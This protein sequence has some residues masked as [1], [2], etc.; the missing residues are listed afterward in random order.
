EACTRLFQS[1][2]Q[3]DSSA[4]R[5]F[6]GTGLGLA[7]S[8]QLVEL[9]GGEIG[10]E[11]QV[12]RGST[13]WFN[14]TFDRSNACSAHTAP[15]LLA[16]EGKRVL[17]VD[18]ND[19]NRRLLTRLL[20]RWQLVPVEAKNGHEAL[21]LLRAAKAEEKRFDLAILDFQM[22]GMDGHD[23]ARAIRAEPSWNALR[24]IML[25]SSLTKEHR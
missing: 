1:F 25:S 13:F 23:L 15:P 5:R 8:K 14:L 2:T 22:P 6:G 16:V 10:V 17:I 4:A 18:D 11:S 3:V 19:T 9:M 20:Q 24:L 21:V 12:G 7:I